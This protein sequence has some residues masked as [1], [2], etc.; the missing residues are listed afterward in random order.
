M[1]KNATHETKLTTPKA[2]KTM[3]QIFVLPSGNTPVNL[4]LDSCIPVSG[5][6]TAAIALTYHA[7]RNLK[8]VL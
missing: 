3:K 1:R 4:P 8:S 6:L 7:V 5:G 2:D